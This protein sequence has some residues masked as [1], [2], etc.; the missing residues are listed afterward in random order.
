MGCNKSV[1]FVPRRGD[2]LFM[3]SFCSGFVETFSVNGV[4]HVLAL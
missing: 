1:V 4:R 3:F 2:W